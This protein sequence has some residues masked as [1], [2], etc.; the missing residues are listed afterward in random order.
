MTNK[1]STAVTRIFLLGSLLGAFLFIPTVKAQ[2]P[3]YDLPCPAGSSPV[4]QEMQTPVPSTG[5]LR[6]NTCVDANGVM[7]FQGTSGITQ[8]SSNPTCP[9]SGSFLYLNTVTN[10]LLLCSNGVLTTAAGSWATV[11]DVTL[12]GVVADGLTVTDAS[13]TNAANP[14]TVTIS[15]T[16]PPF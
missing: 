1:F 11:Y 6:A 14:V 3:I 4:P 9:V 10:Q 16:D 7:T 12:Y 2:Q 8:V 15:G 13:W 5:H